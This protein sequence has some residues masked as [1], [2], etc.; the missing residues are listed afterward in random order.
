MLALLDPSRQDIP[1]YAAYLD[2][3]EAS[4]R[5]VNDRFRRDGW[6]PVVLEI[7]DDF[8]RSVA[9]YTQYDVLLVNAVFDGL[10][11]VAKEAPLVN[12]RD[13]VIVLSRDAGAYEELEPWVV[14]VDPL[15]VAG[16]AEALHVA[17]SLP[18]E[19]R[20]SRAEAIRAHVR[21]HDLAEWLELQLADLDRAAASSV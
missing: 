5:A 19:E 4:A 6:E 11:L 2:E 10:N 14:A 8:P 12:D 1:Q 17:L 16:Q 13:G 21:E 20:R 9:A 3:I 7:R 18:D 15:D